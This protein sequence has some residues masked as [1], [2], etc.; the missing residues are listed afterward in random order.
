MTHENTEHLDFGTGQKKLGV[1][2][3]GMIICIVLTII[4]FHT[5]M[6][7]QYSRIQTIAVIFAAA[8]VQFL[9]QV[10]F[11]LRLNLKSEQGVVNVFA[12][13]YTLVILVCIV[14]GSLW[15][16]ANMNY[17]MVH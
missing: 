4:A 10:F 7:G 16:M 13:I 8:I 2:S 9:V 11:F 6:S 15:I 3:I 1:Y 12:L 5:V 14:S 17:Y